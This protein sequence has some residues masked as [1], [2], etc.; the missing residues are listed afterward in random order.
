L[1]NARRA[2]VFVLLAGAIASGVFF[3]LWLFDA[4]TS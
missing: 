3:G 4:V 2:F 1:T